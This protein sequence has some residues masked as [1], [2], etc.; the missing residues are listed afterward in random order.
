[1]DS[2]DGLFLEE[3]S[4]KINNVITPSELEKELDFSVGNFS[5]THQL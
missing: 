4:D 5:S 1:M 3:D 2:F